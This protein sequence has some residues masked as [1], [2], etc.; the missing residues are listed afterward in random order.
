M[1][2]AKSLWLDKRSCAVTMLSMHVRGE[3]ERPRRKEPRDWL[4]HLVQPSGK[5]DQVAVHAVVA[6][7][8]LPA[9]CSGQF[10]S[11][12]ASP[13]AAVGQPETAP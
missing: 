7:E 2:R 10:S 12:G 8:H 9:R 11:F 6:P 5:D 3:Q 13:I 1:I 4:A